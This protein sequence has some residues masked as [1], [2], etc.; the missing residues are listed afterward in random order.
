MKFIFKTWPISSN[1]NPSVRGV[2]F[3]ASCD[4]SAGY[5]MAK[6]DGHGDKLKDWFFVH[7]EELTPATV[8][9]ADG[10]HRQDHRLR[11]AV[12][13]GA[14]RRSRP[15]PSIGSALGVNSTP[16]FFVNGKRIPGAGVPPQ[17][18]DALIELELKKAK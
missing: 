9:R 18:F 8:R 5:L 4:A 2:N 3:A 14:R 13:E 7:Q 6:A 1:C 16:A 11:R 15:M 10:R 17:Y 12:S